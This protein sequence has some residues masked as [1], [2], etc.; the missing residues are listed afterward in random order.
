MKRTLLMLPFVLTIT[1]V[2]GIISYPGS[3]WLGVFVWGGL[4]SFIASILTIPILS[5]IHL[6]LGYSSIVFLAAITFIVIV[7][8]GIA[9]L[10]SR[11]SL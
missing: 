2:V 8:S 1:S 3:Y 10:P 6:W 4:A 11:A 5:R 7:T 9:H